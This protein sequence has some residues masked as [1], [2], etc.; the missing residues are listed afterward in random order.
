MHGDTLTSGNILEAFRGAISKSITNAKQFLIELGKRFAKSNKA[1]TSMLLQCPI[2]MKYKGKGNIRENIMEM[3]HI[4]AKLKELKLELS[5]DLL[6]HLV[7]ISLIAQYSWFKVSY[8][9][10]KEKWTLNEPMSYLVQEEDRLKY[11]L[12]ESANLASTFKTKGIKRKTHDVAK[13]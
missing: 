4:V 6:V 2:S 10:Q 13:G 9:S 8:N 1:K 5:E 12:I 11:D 7:L 3:Y